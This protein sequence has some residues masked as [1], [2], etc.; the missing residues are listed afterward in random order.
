ML[1]SEL[2]AKQLKENPIIIYMKGTPQFPQC[3]FSAAAV[4]AIA[5]H[6]IPFAHVNVLEQPRIRE[7]LPE[8][9]EWPTFPQ[10]FI[11]GELIGGS[12]IV[13][14]MEKSGTLKP[15]LESAI[16]QGQAS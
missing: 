5:K 6:N 2:I 16:T 9:S 10:L 4:S 1:T 15:A 7:A 13:V 12:D 11:N 8:V 14:D 3:G